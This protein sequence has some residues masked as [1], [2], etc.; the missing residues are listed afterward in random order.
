MHMPLQTPPCTCAY[1]ATTLANLV[2]M[3]RPRSC[4]QVCCAAGQSRTVALTVMYPHCQ[5][6]FCTTLLGHITHPHCS[7]H[8]C[9]SNLRCTLL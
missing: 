3:R 6:T 1:V 2:L 4:T 8:P 5:H 7:Y 9:K